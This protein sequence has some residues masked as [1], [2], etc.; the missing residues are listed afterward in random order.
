MAI[1]Y[2]SEAKE[3]FSYTQ[4]LRRDFHAHPE[5][6]F[7]E[8]RTAGIVA[9]ELRKLGIEITTGVA[10]TGVIGIIEGNGPGPVVLLRFDMDA[11]PIE[12]ETNAPYQ[13]ENPGVMHACGHD[14]HTS[15]GLT[16]AKILHKYQDQW[17]G[18][19]K[20][21]FQPAEEGMGGAK[22]MVEEGVLENPRPDFSLGMHVW[23]DIPVGQIAAAPG[24]IM[25][26][27]DLMTIK[28]RGKGAHGASPH[29]GAD[30][31]LAASQVV[32]AAQSVVA[33]NVNPMET[34]VI[35][36]TSIHGGT[37]FNVIPETV[38]MK[39]TI[40]TFLPEVREVVVSRFSELV[41]KVAEGMGCTA[42]LNIEQ[43]TLAVR[44]DERL[45]ALV[46]ETLPEVLPEVSYLPELRTMGS[47]DMAFLMDDVPGCFVFVG[48]Q[49]K[50][51]GLDYGH[52]HPKFDIDEEALVHGVT[53]ISACAVKLLNGAVG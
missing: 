17:K 2:L 43:V 50:E 32:S 3:Y 8:V 25:A 31:I 45:A 4:G 46:A 7:Q 27:A 36:I 44:N 41:N 5:L 12:E 9:D 22:R 39:G 34:A 10:E 13:S 37:T 38:E 35:S 14:G 48:S 6:G 11:L 30:P 52:H 49:N 23:N 47:E 40:R 20:L 53:L 19:V 15:I 33:R 26:Q 51:K 21:V 16:V 18:T 1:D 24:P 29:L 28:I 42:E